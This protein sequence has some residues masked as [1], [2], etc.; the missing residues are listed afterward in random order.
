MRLR[1]LNC[2]KVLVLLS[3]ALIFGCMAQP[4][5]N[6]GSSKVNPFGEADVSG[7]RMADQSGPVCDCA[8]LVSESQRS[9]YPLI[10]NVGQRKQVQC[11]YMAD[12]L[13]SGV[14]GASLTVSVTPARRESYHSTV[15]A[16]RSEFSFLPEA[17]RQEVDAGVFAQVLTGLIE[18]G[19]LRISLLFSEDTRSMIRVRELIRLEKT[20]ERVN[21]RLFGDRSQRVMPAVFARH[22]QACLSVGAVR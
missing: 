16:L 21:N 7:V 5:A 15:E 11:T 8:Q 20:A 2:V 19:Q 1:S 10:S 9:A 6:E 3:C 12:R 17:F 22:H 14:K 18:D 4:G 13:Q